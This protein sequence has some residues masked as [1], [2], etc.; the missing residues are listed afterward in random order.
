[1]TPIDWILIGIVII[2]CGMYVYS[3]IRLQQAV[4]KHREYEEWRDE[5]DR[6]TEPCPYC[7]AT[8]RMPKDGY[9]YDLDAMR[10]FNRQRKYE[11]IP[12][13]IRKAFEE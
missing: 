10:H 3:R 9:A 7:C 11:Q 2:A 13:A 5:L 12:S 1:M 4:R 8:G 6:T